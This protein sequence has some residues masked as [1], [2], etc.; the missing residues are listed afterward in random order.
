V[1]RIIPICKALGLAGS[2]LALWSV[3]AS[4]A[5]ADSRPLATY[6][7][8]RAADA[9]GQGDAAL[10]AYARVLDDAPT[11]R[12]VASRAYRAAVAGGDAALVR[13]TIAI[14]GKEAP[15]D[16]ALFPLADAARAN[17]PAAFAKALTGLDSGILRVIAPAL[18]GWL[19]ETRGQDGV[20][21]LDKV[22]A[23]S[24][25]ARF[26]AE[27]RALL[28]VARGKVDAGIAAAE[29]VQGPTGRSPVIRAIAELLVA[30][31]PDRV[32]ALLDD[33]ALVAQAKA[34][35]ARPTLAFA[36]SRLLV[37]LA[38][39]LDGE[40][41]S[42]I[43]LAMAR[44]AL[45]CDPTYVPARLV[46]ATQV[47]RSDDPD[48]ALALLDP[49]PLDGPF[50]EAALA[51]RF[52]LLA[53]TDRDP[54]A[55]ALARRRAEAGTAD[56]VDRARYAGLL[57]QA[58]QA[59]AA[60]PWYKR[61]MKDRRFEGNATA[62]LNYAAGLD[63][64]GDWKGA[65]KA[66]TRALALSPDDPQILNYL[67][68]GEITHGGDPIAAI[69][70]LERAHRLAK[71]DASIADSLGWAYHRTGDTAR[72]LPLIEG[73]ASAEPD[74]AEIAEHLGDLYWTAGRRYEARYAWAA[75]SVTAEPRDLAR[76]AHKQAEGL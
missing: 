30:D 56:G 72:A 70:L 57:V 27:N 53:R 38:R 43:G 68:Y 42:V 12:A 11:D 76:L 67:G 19:A 65:R 54:E 7:A 71:D 9:E 61:M 47:A 14:L 75:A 23:R 2:A 51:E 34:S 29:A 17:D 48:R 4:A 6:L 49:I 66:L 50:G 3:P 31:H 1:V 59:K 36:T 64:A 39:E 69:A 55:L 5:I 40:R 32:A 33:P 18:Q 15:P 26:A 74:N 25:A 37:R 44:A 20:A 52:P 62:W 13:R 16:A 28:L 8:A 46:L 73:A 10:A 21:L 41:G 45:D 22:P 35:A 24:L 60:L 58:D 63:A